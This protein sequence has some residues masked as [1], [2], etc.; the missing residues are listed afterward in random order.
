[1]S[2][3]R[4]R[5]SERLFEHLRAA[6]LAEEVEL[7][8]R[9]ALVNS[10]QRDECFVEAL[11]EGGLASVAEI[12]DA[13]ESLLDIP[14]LELSEIGADVTILGVIPADRAETLQVIPLFVVGGSVVLA[15]SDPYDL[16]KID[17]LGFLTGKTILPVF[18]LASDIARHLPIYYG[19]REGSRPGGAAV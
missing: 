4:E 17:Q 3:S 14:A 8:V 15:M 16:A 7:A 18:C 10:K 6:G 12:F 2:L 19:V 11:V 9:R 13:V 5:F 1:M